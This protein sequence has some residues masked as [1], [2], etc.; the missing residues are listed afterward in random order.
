[1]KRPSS[2][3]FDAK[4]QSPPS[5]KCVSSYT[6]TYVTKS[7]TPCYIGNFSGKAAKRASIQALRTEVMEG[8]GKAIPVK[9]RSATGMP[10]Q[11]ERCAANFLPIVRN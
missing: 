5:L 1:M 11:G 2:S 9:R 4:I 8:K 10:S 6:T 7:I 3:N